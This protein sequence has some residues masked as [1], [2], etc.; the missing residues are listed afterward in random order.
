MTGNN[1]ADYSTLHYGYLLPSTY[2]MQPKS[3]QKLWSVS[4][5]VVNS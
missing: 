4:Q 5:V 1:T 2:Q 3:F